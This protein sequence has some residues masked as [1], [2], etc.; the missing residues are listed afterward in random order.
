MGKHNLPA[1]LQHANFPSSGKAIYLPAASGHL[2][3][4]GTTVPSG[5]AGYAP[6]ALFIDYDAAAG[7]QQWINEGTATSCSFKRKEAGDVELGSGEYLKLT[8]LG[9]AITA[10]DFATIILGTDSD[11][12]ISFSSSYDALMLE[13]NNGV[14][15]NAPGLDYRFTLKWVAGQRGKPGINADIQNAAESTRMVTD[16]DFEILGTNA[17]SD[18]VTFYA[19]GGI[20]MQTDGADG[21]EVILLPHLDANQSAWTQVTWGSDQQTRWECDIT[22]HSDITNCIIWAGLKLTNTEVTTDDADQAFFRY[23][24]GVNS[25]K[26]QAI[27][28]IGGTDDAADSGVTVAASTRYHL[29]IKISATR[30]AAFYINGALVETSA[31][32]TTAKDFIPYIGVAADGAAE[33]KTLYVHGQ[34]ISRN[35]G[36]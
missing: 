4:W 28:S 18:D 16:P 23:E 35:M 17:S 2:L 7:S 19:E 3:G 14:Y 24:N 31:A 21:D 25:G 20:A 13:N 29:V 10:V 8:H 12:G 36:A 1:Y 33:A 15:L 32:L 30:T 26:W 9:S 34:E 5:T 11:A 27:S 6:G 22:T